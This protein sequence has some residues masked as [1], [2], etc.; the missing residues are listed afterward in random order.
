M[1]AL[2]KRKGVHF[3]LYTMQNYAKIKLANGIPTAK[4]T[5]NNR[6]NIIKIYLYIWLGLIHSVLP[7]TNAAGADAAGVIYA[8]WKHQ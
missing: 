4:V 2:P 1:N 6:T 3:I 7:N 5:K 8:N